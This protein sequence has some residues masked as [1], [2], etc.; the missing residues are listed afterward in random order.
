VAARVG[1]RVS[2]FVWGTREAGS[3]GRGRYCDHVPAPT[4]RLQVGR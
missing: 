3:V 1:V 4:S 2:V